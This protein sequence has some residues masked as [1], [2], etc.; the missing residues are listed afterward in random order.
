MIKLSKGFI[1]GL[2]FMLLF[3]AVISLF[4]VYKNT[5]N[6]NFFEYV[7]VFFF[8]ISLASGFLILYH[9]KS[10]IDKRVDIMKSPLLTLLILIICTLVFALYVLKLMHFGFQTKE[11]LLWQL[12]IPVFSILSF[13]ALVKVHVKNVKKAMPKS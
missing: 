2:F 7:D 1:M 6:L 5:A 9:E 4:F 3:A 12:S 8:S 13:I 11:I 10:D